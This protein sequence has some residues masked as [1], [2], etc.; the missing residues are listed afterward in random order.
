MS[1]SIL[2]TEPTLSVEPCEQS[3]QERILYA[4]ADS[5]LRKV[6]SNAVSA[7]IIAAGLWSI[8]YYHTGQTGALIWACFIHS[9]QLIFLF[10][11]KYFITPIKPRDPVYR[12]NLH[13]N[14]LVLMG[15]AWGLAPWMLLPPDNLPLTSLMVVILVGINSTGLPAW[16]SYRRAVFSFSIPMIIGLCSALVWH[17]GSENL[18]LV[19]ALS[20][21]L[22]ATIRFGLEQNRVLTETLRA[23]YENEDQAQRQTEQTRLA[24][25]ANLEKTRF[26]ASASHDLRQPLHS[27][28]LFG[29][30]LQAK[31]KSTPDESLARSLMICVEALESSFTSMLDISKLDAGVIKPKIQ[32]VALAYLFQ[33]LADSYSRQAEALG[34]SLRFKP[35]GK[36]T[37]A[38]PALL[39]HMLGNLVHNALKFTRNGGAVVVARTRGANLSVEVWDSGKGIDADELPRIFDEYYQLDNPE[40]DRSKG[41]G[42]GLSIV[43]RLSKLLDMPL[44]VH[45]VVGH[46]T[47]FKI[48]M[49]LAAPP[50][51]QATPAPRY[52]IN[53]AVHGL[54]GKRILIVDDEESVRNSTAEI[55]RLHGMEV[56]TADGMQQA[57]EIAQRPDQATDILITDLRLRGDDN[58]I[59]LVAELNARLGRI[60]PALLI[61]GDVAPERVHL[62]QQSGLQ[63]LYK[64][65][66]INDLLEALNNLLA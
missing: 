3:V 23:R 8:F 50:V 64:P 19:V 48:Q 49:P 44:S 10:G 36:W 20:L 25:R 58:G 30:A 57:L 7:I 16:A 46:G 33:Q 26:L 22:F 2:Q 65:V 40:R 6:R 4:Q 18:F 45:S 35:G 13:C 28:A 21:Y 27:I 38:D 51:E 14:I 41:L 39:R 24:E 61:T 1:L 53:S 52:V 56:E 55:L 11:W 63:V 17:G 60:L 43:K 54:T 59:Q 34:L 37:Y 12:A 15:I 9:T 66:K 62:A 29:S 32:P 5:L 42:M 47:V 31:L